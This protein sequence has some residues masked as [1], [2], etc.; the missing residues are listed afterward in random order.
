VRYFDVQQQRPGLPQD[1]AALVTKIGPTNA[2]IHLVNLN[3]FEGREVVLQAGAF[4]EH[5]FRSASYASRTSEYPGGVYKYA[6]PPLETEQL[7]V[8]IEDKYFQVDLPPASEIVLELVMERYVNQP[9]YKS[10][11]A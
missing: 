6:A 2:T 5:S 1:V 11:F 3:P 10:L 7:E 9:S 4:G 8:E